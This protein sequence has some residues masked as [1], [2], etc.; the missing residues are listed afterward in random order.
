M[1][2]VCIVGYG[3]IGP[4]HAK[5]LTETCG[6]TLHS[7]CDINKAAREKCVN[8][9]GCNEF[10]NYDDVIACDEIDTV[11]ICTPHFLHFKMI[12]KALEAGK[13]V[14]CEKPIVMTKNEL[15]MLMKL[16]GLEHIAIVFQNRVNPCIIKLKELSKEKKIV[17]LKGFVTWERTYDYY[18]S[19]DWRGKYASEGGGVLI[20]QAVHTLDL[21]CYLAEKVQSVSGITSNFTIPEIEV[22]D[23]VM[24]SLDFVS[25][26]RAVFFATNAFKNGDL[27][28]I[29]VVFDDCIAEYNNGKLYIDN[30]LIC[31]DIPADGS[32]SYWGIGHSELIKNY[33]ERNEY[34]TPYDAENTMRSMFAI[35]ESAANNGAKI[36][37]WRKEK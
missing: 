30:E 24:A 4:I 6:T 26:A 36:N 13:D 14:V 3:S 19:G 11:H 31:R 2:N 18:K 9:Y 23:S 10:E 28:Y 12:K 34:F 33:Y 21:L 8:E 35:Y 25:G 20:N 1:K 17:S 22:E 29:K 37:V 15:D 27:P 7:V 16:K 5:A 32:K